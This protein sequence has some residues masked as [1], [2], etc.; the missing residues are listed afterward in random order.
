MNVLDDFAEVRAVKES[1]VGG[2]T[3]QDGGR[4]SEGTVLFRLY[5]QASS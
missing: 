2:T 1:T 4:G 5:V 3:G